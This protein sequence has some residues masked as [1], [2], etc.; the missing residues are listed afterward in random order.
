MFFDSDYYLIQGAKMGLAIVKEIIPD[1]L[2]IHIKFKKLMGYNLDFRNPKTFNEKLQFLKLH[3][4]NPK[5]QN[6]VDKVEVKSYVAKT[7]GS[8][9]VVPTIG[10]WNDFSEISF[11]SLPDKFV[12]KCSHDSGSYIVCK[13]KQLLDW[14]TV[15][16]QFEKSLKTNH[17]W[18]GREYPYKG[19]KPRIIVEEYKADDC[20]IELSQ[21]ELTDYKFYCFDGYVDCVMVCYDRKSGDPKFYF[22]DHEWRLKRINIRGKNAPNDFSLPKPSCIDEMF[23]LAAKLSKGIPFVRVDL[24]QCDGK[25]FFGEMTFY[26]QSGFDPNYLPET[27]LYFG[28]LIDLN[29]SYNLRKNN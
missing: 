9:Y 28:S 2:F 12:L 21:Q 20:S 1:K 7:I 25:I 14:N 3:D 8:A 19:I 11:E 27:D 18:V 10:V 17:F 24:Y 6:L 29:K 23:A 4:R 5:Y 15:Q 16:K 22:F 13:E 26:P